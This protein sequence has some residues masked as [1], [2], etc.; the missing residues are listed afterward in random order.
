MCV[1]LL[2]TSGHL[3]TMN[4]LRPFSSNR[5]LLRMRYFDALLTP[6]P[7]LHY[8]QTIYHTSP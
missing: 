7:N 1:A 5:Q 4:L 8:L 2:V 3:K 6:L